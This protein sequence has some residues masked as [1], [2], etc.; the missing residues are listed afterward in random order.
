[1]LGGESLYP[2]RA[3]DGVVAALAD[4]RV[5]VLNGARQ[6]GKSTLARLVAQGRPGA[7]VRYLDDAAVRAAAG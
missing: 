1:M 7:E 4:T 6:S 3:Y 2:R 5:V